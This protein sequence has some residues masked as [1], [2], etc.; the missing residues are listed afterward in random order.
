MSPATA[1]WILTLFAL[2]PCCQAPHPVTPSEAA[3][4]STLCRALHEAPAHG[5][6]ERLPPV[7]ELGGRAEAPLL[8]LLERA[9]GAPG[10]QASVAVL[11][12]IGGAPA[13]EACR[14]LVEERG[15]LAVEAAL[16]LGRL[17]TDG[18]DPVLTACLQ[19]TFTDATLRTAAAC[20][21][22]RHGETTLAPRWIA[23]VVRAGSPGARA[24]ERELGVPQKTRWAQERYFVQRLLL[25]LGHQ[26]LASALDTDA[27]WP[28]LEALAPKILARLQQQRR[29]RDAR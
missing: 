11:G 19:D 22:S 3:D 14:V 4:P 21:L 13:A 26:D 6:S 7:L 24:D 29:P 2:A 23:A 8:E 16:A 25:A 10:A 27:P 5:W 28:V 18:A 12:S 9:P 1:P 17:P 15:P 20:S